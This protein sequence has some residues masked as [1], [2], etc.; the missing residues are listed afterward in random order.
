MPEDQKK[1]KKD[2]RRTATK[3][4]ALIGPMVKQFIGATHTAK[5][6]G[7]KLAYTFICCS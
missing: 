2:K 1:D 5:A 6:E 3:A 7:K 4:A